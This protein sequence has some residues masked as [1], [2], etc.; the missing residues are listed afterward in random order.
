MNEWI[1]KDTYRHKSRDRTAMELSLSCI[2]SFVSSY[3]TVFAVFASTYSSEASMEVHPDIP[4]FLKNIAMKNK[5]KSLMK[6]ANWVPSVAFPVSA[7]FHIEY[8]AFDN[9]RKLKTVFCKAK[10][11]PQCKSYLFY[12]TDIMV[13]VPYESLELY[14]STP[15][16][17][18]SI[19]HIAGCHYHH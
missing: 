16:W 18:N 5:P 15:E 4:S 13:F 6:Y 9:C 17:G 3:L 19:I 10:T 1:S 11:P 12:N 2:Y 8:E 7:H 14:K